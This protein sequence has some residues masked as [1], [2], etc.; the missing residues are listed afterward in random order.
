MQ[1]LI[2]AGGL[3]TRLGPLGQG[4]PKS[5]VPIHDKPFLFWQI[6]LLKK[7]GVTDIL[8]LVGHHGEQIESYIASVD[9]GPLKITCFQEGPQLLGTAGAVARACQLGCVGDEF[10]L[11]YGDSFLPIDFHAVTQAFYTSQ[12][13]ALMTVYKND[14]QLEKSNVEFDSV[15]SMVSLYDKFGKVKKSSELRFVDYGLSVFK[16]EVFA[17]IKPG[18]QADLAELLHQ[19]SRDGELAGFEAKE[20]FFEIGSIRGISEFSAWLC[21]NQDFLK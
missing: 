19:L 5:L 17:F 18:T 20:R 14:N 15:H 16:R 7:M 1:C 6:Q 11:L 13:R 2:L 21:A 10:L 12:Q 3:G 4:R 8:L 9:W